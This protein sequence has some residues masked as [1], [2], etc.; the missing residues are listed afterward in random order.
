[1]KKRFQSDLSKTM[2]YLKR[3]GF[4]DTFFAAAERLGARAGSR[5]SYVMPDDGELAKQR[6]ET[7]DAE[8][9]PSIT[10]VMPAYNPDELFFREALSS[11]LKQSYPHWKLVI[12]DASDAEQY[13]AR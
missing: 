2:K 7:G 3:N 11:V 13:S 10:I 1:M 9:W 8:G 6:K 5:Y 4:R 12:A